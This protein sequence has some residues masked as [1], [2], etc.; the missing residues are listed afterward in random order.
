MR[1]I[2]FLNALLAAL[3][4]LAGC[5]ESPQSAAPLP[6][7]HF[8]DA[9]AAAGIDFVHTSGRSGRKYGV[10]TIGSGVAFL[11]C[12]ND[13]YMDLYL[14]NGG[15][16][17]GHTSPVRPRNALYHNQGDGTFVD[18]ALQLGL[19]DSSYGMGASAGDYDNDGDTDLFVANFGP[20][21][22]YRNGGIPAAWRFSEVGAATVLAQDTSWS[23]GSA[24]VDYDLDG[25]LDLYVANYL[26]YGFE[27]DQVGADG[28]L[29]RPR[30]H[31]APTEYPGRRD[32]LYRNEGDDRFTD[33]T[34]AAGLLNVAC[35]ELGAVF[36]DFDEDGDPDLFQGNDATPNFLYRNEGD[37]TFAEIGL[38][39]GVAYNDAGKPEG[40]MGV[41][42]GDIDG[43]GLQDLVMTNFQWESN[44]LYRNLGGG[45][46]R[47]E[48]MPRNIGADSFARLAFGINLFDADN[49]GDLD[50]Y[51]ANGHIDEDID[52]FDPQATYAQLDHFYLNDGQGRFAEVS[53][54]V[55]PGFARA[56]VGRGSA[57]ADYDNDGDLDLV[58]L[59][60]HQP[61]VLLRNDTRADN[62]WIALDLEGTQSNRDGLGARVAVYAGS[63]T[64]RVHSRSSSSY[65]SQSDPRLFFGLGAQ[66]RV[67]RIQI[68]WPSGRRQEVG[69]TAADQVLRIVEPS[70]EPEPVAVQSKR[71]DN[72][73]PTATRTLEDFW[74]TSPAVLPQTVLVPVASPTQADLRELRTAARTAPDLPGPHVVLGNALRQLRRYTEAADQYAQA[75]RLDPDYTSA[76]TALGQLHSARGDHA[77]AMAAFARAAR[78]DPAAAQPHYFSGNIALR[79]N[80]LDEASGH[81]EQALARDPTYLQAYINLAGLHTRQTDYGPAIE[82][83]ER[84]LAALPGHPELAFLL[85]RVLFIQTHYATAL[86]RLDEV[87]RLEPERS[88]AWELAAQAHLQMGDSK[89]ALES[90]NQGLQRDSTNAALHARLGIVLLETEQ[91]KRA[92]DHL[93]RA[94]QID[95]D[96]AEAHYSLGQAHTRQGRRA[97]G[98]EFL[99]YF[100]YLQDNYQDLLDYKTA[101]SINPDDAR[102]Y[103]D[104]GA[105]YSRIGRYEGAR[106][107]YTV[108]LRLD[109]QHLDA[110]NNLGNIY[111]RRRQLDRAIAAYQ[112]VLE[113]D[114]T[115]ARAC[116]N[117][118]N[119]YLLA[120]RQ[121]EAVGAFERA[122]RLQPDYP[123]PRNALVRL[124][125]QQGRQ[126]EATAHLEAYRRLT[127]A[128]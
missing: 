128:P 110:L 36:F 109:P 126:E 44:T 74:E 6:T 31:L 70:A 1:L 94:V 13:G 49:D 83:Y 14:V 26:D 59:N 119:A 39:A 40:T 42:I 96:H 103:Y 88:R 105:V 118:G 100:Q 58:V 62:H 106:Q 8:V 29:Q 37:G 56:A 16:L 77:E 67:D 9:T 71:I 20:N 19:A 123:S 95:P 61:A 113:G 82:V 27:G 10:E 72:G 57:V 35:R 127:K 66:E 32:F 47:D 2:P 114:S 18:R 45:L 79:R 116:N 41:D 76:Y 99:R 33:V 64:L 86:E 122:V 30:R 73:G 50:L 108:C 75:L 125:R 55:G 104:L 15:D 34:A 85:A 117:L 124:Y 115:Y 78:I 28:R 120:G 102:A 111:L 89:A 38:A 25:D 81:Y 4:A 90:L 112:Q 68:D 80:R 7:V 53:Q 21:A 84:G 24:F 5:A 65:L 12:D 101:I 48:S 69:P 98:A 92:I 46:F 91:T 43:D 60:T 87:A 63:R 52:A 17:L 97:Q 121:A 3:V 23:T 51:V 22:L 11:D 107:M 54:R 93:I